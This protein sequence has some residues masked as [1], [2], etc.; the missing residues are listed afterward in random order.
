LLLLSLL[1]AGCPSETVT[2]T[3]VTYQSFSCETPTQIG[4][5]LVE[6]HTPPDGKTCADCFL[7]ESC[8]TRDSCRIFTQPR[9]VSVLADLSS[10][11]SGVRF[12]DVDLQRRACLRVMAFSL[13]PLG[14][15]VRGTQRP[16]L[17]AFNSEPVDL[18]ADGK[19]E[20]GVFCG[21]SDIPDGGPYRTCVGALWEPRPPDGGSSDV[22]MGGPPRDLGPWPEFGPHP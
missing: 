15:Q 17:C 7:G 20:L 14:C 11:T 13:A 21:P 5:L 2:S 18:T 6:L 9:T 8:E 4:E 12:A 16:H 22:D 3:T 10:L 1:A 19:V